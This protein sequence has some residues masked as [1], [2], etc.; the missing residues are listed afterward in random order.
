MPIFFKAK[1]VKGVKFLA[2]DYGENLLEPRKF[3]QKLNFICSE[4]S[5]SFK[6]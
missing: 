5:S 3:L 2:M 4:K 6:K 1:V